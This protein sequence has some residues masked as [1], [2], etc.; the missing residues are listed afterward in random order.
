MSLLVQQATNRLQI[1]KFILEWI[2]Y[3]ENAGK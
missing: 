3:D 1:D 2:K